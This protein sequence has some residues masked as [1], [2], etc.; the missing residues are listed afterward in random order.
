MFDRE[1]LSIKPLSQRKHSIN[2]SIV[3]R[4]G[5][6]N[7]IENDEKI[8]K[9]AS[10]IS[11]AKINNNANIIF[12]GGHVIRSGTQ[13]YLL[14]LMERGYVSCLAMSGAGII[15]D[16]ELALIGATTENVAHYIKNGQF[17]LWKETGML[18]DIINQG[19]RRST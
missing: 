4:L 2:I 6:T 15:H 7:K 9:I 16:Y 3:S 10:H 13:E 17:G 19:E 8:T 5:T 14:D 18:N 11:L 12:I 1:A